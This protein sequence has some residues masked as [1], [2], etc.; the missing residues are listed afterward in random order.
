MTTSPLIGSV[1]GWP[2]LLLR[3]EG[4][5]MFAASIA[6]FSV[7][8]QQWWLYPLLLL[9]PDIFMLGYLR[10]TRIGAIIY[11]LGHSYPAAAVVALVG[12]V[13]ASPLTVA[14][15]VIWFGH[16]GWDRM[17]GYGLKYATS[18]KHTHLGDLEKSKNSAPEKE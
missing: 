4:A 9:V 12:F 10:N 14:L 5:T 8:G 16:I 11:N 6:V 17:F 13:F 1:I 7:Q 15:G 2:K 18:F 3:I